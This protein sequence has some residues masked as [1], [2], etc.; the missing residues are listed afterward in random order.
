[1]ESK[2][3]F[4][5]SIGVE[6]GYLEKYIIMSRHEEV[7]RISMVKFQIDEPFKLGWTFLYE[8]HIE[9]KYRHKGI[10][11]NVIENIGNELSEKGQNGILMN[12]ITISGAKTMYDNLGWKRFKDNDCWQVLINVNVSDF[13]VRKT[14]GVVSKNLLQWQASSIS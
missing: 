6:L 4:I 7:G 9:P 12:A 14:H 5:N 10:A 11:K 13:F 3:E 1:M 2:L 8:I